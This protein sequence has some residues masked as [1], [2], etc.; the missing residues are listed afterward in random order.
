MLPNASAAETLPFLLDLRAAASAE[1]AA[2]SSPQI[3]WTGERGVGIEHVFIESHDVPLSVDIVQRKGIPEQRNESLDL[4]TECS[5]DQ[6]NTHS[7]C[8]A[9]FGQIALRS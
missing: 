8:F 5:L 7:V 9:S 3:L 1:I 4:L 2:E 6:M